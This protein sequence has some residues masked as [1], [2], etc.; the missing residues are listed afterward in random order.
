VAVTIVAAVARNGVIGAGGDLPWHLPDELRLFKETTLGHVLV[1]GRRTYESIG[2]PLPG[3]TTVVVTRRPDWSPGSD[4]VVVAH[5]VEDA[6]ARA[7]AIDVDVFVVG[8]GEIYAGALPHADRLVLTFVDLEP[9]G[10]TTFPE[11]DWSAWRETRR[12]PGEGWERVTYER[13]AGGG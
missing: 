12:E 13:V 3:R 5:A 11:V 2:R 4:E 7:R 10:D 6:L 9:E 8:G 1:M